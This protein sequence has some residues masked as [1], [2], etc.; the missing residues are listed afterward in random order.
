MH[1]FHLKYPMNIINKT[2]QII[3]LSKSDLSNIAYQVPQSCQKCLKTITLR[4]FK[5]NM[6]RINETQW[7]HASVWRG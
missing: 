5:G 2:Y 1:K 3:I 4:L 6:T 7:W